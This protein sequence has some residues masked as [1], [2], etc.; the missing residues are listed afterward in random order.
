MVIW[1]PRASQIFSHFDRWAWYFGFGFGFGLG[2]LS[3][4]RMI[5]KC[6]GHD[7]A[8]RAAAFE[9]PI[10]F[11]LAIQKNL[12]SNVLCI[13]FSHCLHASDEPISPVR[14]SWRF[15]S[16]RPQKKTT[17]NTAQQSTAQHSTKVQKRQMPIA[18]RHPVSGS[19]KLSR[20][21]YDSHDNPMRIAQAG[22]AGFE[23]FGSLQVPYTAHVGMFLLALPAPWMPGCAQRTLRSARLTTYC[24]FIC[25]SNRGGMM[26]SCVSIAVLLAAWLHG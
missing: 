10:S 4:E 5:P 22:Q 12:L 19:N 21:S 9:I 15:A 20:D 25:V 2:L 23:L 16:L 6:D 8:S 14:G 18:N 17:K 24:M 1:T 11:C 26:E 13:H 3:L 7:M